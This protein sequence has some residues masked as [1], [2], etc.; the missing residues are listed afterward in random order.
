MDM[1]EIVLVGPRAAA[2]QLVAALGVAGWPAAVDTDGPGNTGID[3]TDPAYLAELA[4]AGQPTDVKAVDVISGRG[5]D[6]LADVCA[7]A[8]RHGFWLRLHGW[9]HAA[10]GV[11]PAPH[12]PDGRFDLV[13]AVSNLTADE[14][15]I[16]AEL[17][18]GRAG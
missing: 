16:V 8:A 14:R 5:E 11:Q 3:N 6:D 13:S 12:G 18:A 2:D 10:P 1:F 4:E 7:I 9:V 15:A 17:L